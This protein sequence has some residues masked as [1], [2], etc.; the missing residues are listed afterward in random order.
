MRRVERR[1]MSSPGRKAGIG[2]LLVSPGQADARDPAS[3]VR[4]GKPQIDEAFPHDSFRDM[5]G[6]SAPRSL[7]SERYK[8]VYGLPGHDEPAVQRQEKDRRAD[9]VQI[10]ARI[11]QDQRE[12]AAGHRTTLPWQKTAFRAA[13]F[14]PPV[15]QAGRIRG[16]QKKVPLQMVMLLRR[17]QLHGKGVAQS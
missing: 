11:E 17:Q 3:G 8:P 5:D 10:K 7:R 1:F 15:V 2:P 16:K 6:E 13:G 12:Q 4:Q 9:L 14:A